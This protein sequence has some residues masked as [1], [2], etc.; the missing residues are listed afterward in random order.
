MEVKWA[1]HVAEIGTI[2]WRQSIDQ[3]TSREQS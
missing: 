1:A 3:K 2:K